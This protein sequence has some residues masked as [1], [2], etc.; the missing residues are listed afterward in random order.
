MVIIKKK[1]HRSIETLVL[2]SVCREVDKKIAQ[3]S[4]RSEGWKV[5]HRALLELCLHPW[6]WGTGMMVTKTR[7]L[8]LRWSVPGKSWR[9]VVLL[10]IYNLDSYSRG[11]FG[12][13]E[14][15]ELAPYVATS[16]RNRAKMLAHLSS[17]RA[18][19]SDRQSK[20]FFPWMPILC[21]Q[22][23]RLARRLKR[24][25]EFCKDALPIVLTST[26]C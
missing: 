21:E 1:K 19:P 22:Q 5:G 23:K 9:R 14:T 8:P 7:K 13:G 2:S 24:T 10:W 11:N 16:R 15:L 26:L 4:S 20:I 3:L 12:V 6:S 17:I 18:E 25:D